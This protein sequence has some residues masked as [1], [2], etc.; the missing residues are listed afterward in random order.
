[1]TKK[2]IEAFDMVCLLAEELAGSIYKMRACRCHGT[3][4]VVTTENG[5][6]FSTPCSCTIAAKEALGKWNK[7]AKGIICMEDK[8]ALAS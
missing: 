7:Q 6:V 8:E 3:G 1:M 5:K 2:E 4:V